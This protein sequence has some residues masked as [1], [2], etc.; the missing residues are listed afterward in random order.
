MDGGSEPSEHSLTAWEDLSDA[1]CDVWSRAYTLL[2]ALERLEIFKEEL[3]IHVLGAQWL[4]EG[5]PLATLQHRW[6][7][8]LKALASRGAAKSACLRLGLVG[9][10]AL[11][12]T[13]RLDARHQESCEVNHLHFEVRYRQGLYH[14]VSF[15]DWP[16]PDVVCAFQ[17]GLWGYAT[18]KTSIVLALTFGAPLLI[19]SYNEEEADEEYPGLK[20]MEHITDPGDEE[21]IFSYIWVDGY[22]KCR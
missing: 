7:P 21:G 8:L 12:A 15:D 17:P 11:G 18:W 9:P 14:E 19:T 13:A 3:T 5:G 2:K 1:E 20:K 10:T 6:A 4:E 22:F 16:A